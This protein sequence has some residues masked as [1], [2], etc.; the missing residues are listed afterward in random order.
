LHPD[1]EHKDAAIYQG[2]AF[3]DVYARQR[4][5]RAGGRILSDYVCLRDRNGGGLYDRNLAAGAQRRFYLPPYSRAGCKVLSFR[6]KGMRDLI[7][8]IILLILAWQLLRCEFKQEYKA[9]E[10]AFN[11]SDTLK[12]F[13]VDDSITEIKPLKK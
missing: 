11:G 8:V 2:G 7:T 1:N 3:G 10:Q 4:S 9:P 12:I 6:Y 13:F 5:G